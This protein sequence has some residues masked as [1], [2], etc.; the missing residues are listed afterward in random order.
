ME[1][2]TKQLERWWRLPLSVSHHGR[3]LQALAMLLC[4]MML[5]VPQRAGAVA[6]SDWG[7]KYSF[8]YRY[9]L[10]TDNLSKNDS[11]LK[12]DQ[13]NN[14]NSPY[15]QFTV[16]YGCEYMGYKEGFMEAGNG[17][18]IWA[19]K[20]G[21]S[22]WEKI[23]NIYTNE[24]FIFFVR[25]QASGCAKYENSYTTTE[26]TVGHY[27]HQKIRWTL[28]IQWRNCNIKLK[29]TG[30]WCKPNGSDSGS[31]PEKDANG[32]PKNENLTIFSIATPYTFNVRSISWNTGWSISPD[33]TITVPYKF[34]GTSRNT[35]GNTHI[36]TQI[37]GGY[38]STIGYKN[39]NKYANGSYTF[40]LKDIDM[41][42]RKKFTITPYH[43]FTHDN[44]KDNK[45]SRKDYKQFASTL[46]FSPFP[47][48][49]IENTEFIQLSNQVKLTW[50]ADNTNYSMGKWDTRWII[51]RNGVLIDSVFQ[52]ITEE[53][54][55]NHNYNSDTGTY[56]YIDEK[57]PNET[58]LEYEIYYV[59][60]DWPA[61]TKVASLKSI[62][63]AANSNKVNT[64]RTVPVK[65]AEAKSYPDSIVFTWTSDHY[66]SG[67]GHEF[68][69]YVDNETS[70]IYTIT[71]KDMQGEFKWI[72]RTTDQH[73][74][75]QAGIDEHGVPYVEEPLNACGPHTYRIQ[76]VVKDKELVDDKVVF[77]KRAIGNGTRFYSLD[78]TKGNHPGKVKLAWRVNLQGSTDAKTYVV[79]RRTAENEDEAW[80]QLTRM[81]S[82]DENLTYDDDTPLPGVYYD[83]RVTV[84]DKCSDGTETTNDKTDIGFAKTTGTV[85]GRIT[86]GSAGN[87]VV[88]ADVEAKKTG[89]SGESGNQYRSMH[90]TNNTG[91]VRWT[92]PNDTYAANNF[93]TGDFSIQLWMNPS[94]L[95]ETKTVRLNG[96]T[97]YVGMDANGKL[98]LVNG[99]NTLT[100]NDLKLTAGKYNHVALTRKAGTLTGYLI[101][102]DTAGMA[103]T[104]K[105]VLT[106]D[107]ALSLDG[108]TQFSMGYYQGYADEFRLWTKC[109][110]EA[111]VMENYDHLLVGN[112]AGLETYWTFDEGLKRK[113]FDYSRTLTVYHQHHGDVGNNTEADT[114]TPEEL[115]LKAKTDQ[116]GNFIIQGV[117]FSGEG[118][119]YA[120][121]PRLNSHEFSPTQQLRFVS[122][123]SL[124]HNGTDFTDISSFPVSGSI[125]YSGTTYPVE[126]VN[127][128]VDGI[129]CT[130]DGKM[131]TTNIDG[132]FEISVPIGEHY[133]QAV[134]NGHVFVNDGRYPADP[135]GIGEKANFDRKITGLEFRDTT[136]VNFTGRVVGGD[137]ENAY[138]V[139][140][141][142]SQNNIGI[143]RLTLNPVNTSPYINAVKQKISDTSFE[144]VYNTET[145]PV[146][147]ATDKINSKSW[148]G[149]GSVPEAR[150]IYIETDSLT[151]E[152]SALLP[153]LEYALG[154]MVVRNT[155]TIVGTGMTIDLTRATLE[156]SDTL[157]LDD[158]S[159]QI[160]TY[161]TKL[162][163]AYHSEPQLIVQQEGRT[164]GSFGIK[165]YEFK[166][167]TTTTT[168]SDI[169]EI[170]AD[171]K[172]KY[173]YGVPGH[174]AP[175]FREGLT[176][177]FKL[178]GYEEYKNYDGDP[179]HE[180]PVVKKVPLKDVEVIIGN[181]LSDGQAVWIVTGQV[182]ME[183]GQTYDAVAGQVVELQNNK[184]RLDENGIAKY[185]WRAGVPNVSSPYTRTISM[186][187]D[188]N[189]RQYQWNGSGLEGIILGDL[190][191]G[192]NFMT[193]GTDHLTMILRD[194][195]GTG[196]SA[197]WST[198]STTTVTTLKNDTWSDSAE[199][200]FTSHLGS[201]TEIM[202]GNVTGA[203]AGVQ[204]VTISSVK[205][206][207]KD[208]LTTHVTME[209]EGESGETIEE[210]TTIT[211]AV[212]TSGEPDF[213][214]ADG[215]I[216]IGNSTNIIFGNARRVGFMKDKSNFSIG[217]RNVI[218]TSMNLDGT[219]FMYTQGYIK[220]TLL[221][222]FK[223]L[224]Q[225]MLLT[226]TQA[227]ID[228]YNPVHDVGTHNLGKEAGNLYLTK[229]TPD[230][231]NFGEEGTYT[232]V[233]PDPY[234]EMPNSAKKSK[235]DMIAWLIKEKYATA[236][237]VE[238]INGQIATWERNLEL[239]EREKVRAYEL[240]NVKDS[241]QFEN[242]SF[243]GGSS[244]TY[245]IE[246]DS[247]HTSSWEWNV[248]A[249]IKVANRLGFE[250]NKTGVDWD[251]EITA[252]GGRHESRDSV[253]STTTSFS[254]TL[255][256]EGSDA[257]TVDVYQYGAFG[258]IF[259][260]RGGQTCNPY[261]DKDTTCYY[262]PGTVIMDKTMQ[263]EVPTISVDVPVISDVPTGSAANYSLHLGNG[264]EIGEDVAYRLYFLEETNPKGAQLSIDGK[265]LT[266]E[267]RL[268][269]VP[270]NQTLDKVLQ[271][272]QTDI[273]ELD[274]DSIAVVFASDSQPEDI[275]SVV[276]LSAHFTPSSSPVT[277]AMSTRTM[278]VLSGADLVLTIKDFDRNYKNLKAFRLQ[279][280]KEGSTDWTQLHEYVLN[281]EDLRPGNNELLPAG[282][283]VS[284][285]KPFAAFSDGNYIF[286][287]ESAATYGTEEVYRYS[288]EMALVKDMVKPRPLGTPEPADGVLDIG[289]DVT[290]TF[291]ETI[292]KGE[293]TK[294]NNF[295]VTGVLN[296]AEI[297]HET[298]LSV[299]SGSVAAT[300][301]TGINLA[302]KDFSIDTWVNI[303]T[304]GTLLTHG[305]G[306]NKLTVGTDAS[307]KLVVKIGDDT[308]TSTNSVPTGKWA[309]LTLNY[310]HSSLN[311]PLP[312]LNASVATADETVS[313]FANTDVAAYTGNGP[314]SV[315]ISNTDAVAAKA[316]MHE[317][318]LWDEAHDLTTALANRTKTKAP[319]TRHL[320][321]YWK[322]DEGEGK[323]IRDYSRSRNMTMANETW[324]LNNE[325]KAVTLDGSHYVT[326]DA[327]MLPI[328]EY[329]DYAVE[330]WMRG[331][332]QAGEAR[333]IQMGDIA[334][335]LN[336]DG[337]LQLK[338][339]DASSTT[340]QPN[341]EFVI[342]NSKLTD[343]AWHHI[344]LNVLRQGAAAVYVDGK[345]CLT[346]NAANV[347]G[348][349]TDRFVVGA[350]RIYG[351]GGLD[352]YTYDNAFKGEVDEVRV[353][354]ATMN[355][356]LLSK[357]RKLRFTGTEGGL[358]AYYPFETK[359]TDDYNQIV[360]VGT[361]KDLTGSGLQAQLVAL[362]GSPAEIG[363][364]NEA[365]ALRTKK[366]ETNVNFTY[367]A[368]DEKIVIEIDED[369][370]TIEGCTLNFNVRNVGDLNGNYSN[371]AIWSAFVNRNELVWAD[372]ALSL[373]QPVETSSSVTATI[374]NKGGKQQM[375]TLGG[376]PAWLT[377]SAEYGTTNPKSESQ[378]TFTVSPATPIGK[379]EETIYLKGNDGI[380][381]PL[382]INVK[383]TG[384]EPLW[385]VNTTDYRE[386]MNIIGNLFILDEMS[387]DEDD[388]V[389][390][391]I[392]DECRGVAHP[393]YDKRYDSYFVTMNVYDII[394]DD[395]AEAK[396]NNPSKIEFKAYDASTGI[397][398]PVVKPY[399][400]GKTV[401]ETML[402]NSN[403]LVG[404]YAKPMKFTATDEVEQNIELAKG[405]NWM[406]LGVKPDNFTVSDVFSKAHG[407]VEFVKGF[408]SSDEFDGDDWLI[409]TL[410]MNNREMYAVQT[411][412]AMTL[413]VTG[414]KVK[415]NDEPITVKNGW[416]WVAFNSLSVMSLQEGLAGMI[417]Q[418]EEIIK[419]QRGV[420][421]YDRYEWKGNLKQLTPGL[422]YKIQGKQARTFT[423]P[424]KTATGAA[425]R[426]AQPT[427]NSQLSTLN[428]QITTFT[429]VDYRNYPANMVLIAQVVADG[430][431]VSGV[432]LG[433]FAGEECREAAV[434]DERGMIYIT[435]PGDEPC[436]LTFSAAINGQWSMVNN[437]S[438]TYETDAVIG[439]PKA[440][441]IIDLANATGIKSICDLQIDNSRFDTDA[442]YDLQGRKIVN[443][444]SVNRKLRKGV[445][446]MNGQKK[447][448]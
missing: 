82:K 38:N 136:L 143:T 127:F 168:I 165:S 269:K 185:R 334:L 129:A 337:E 312:T 106:L 417:P 299:G 112:E 144:Y 133:I 311:S 77:A 401:P 301:E 83:Y 256:E 321:G 416:S 356:D 281:E 385:A 255:A 232:V 97:C 189:G 297:D 117:P 11:K 98:T 126:G 270:G 305:Q 206:E 132:E 233:V 207:A 194:P 275:C 138:P 361:P 8:L 162:T 239:N 266:S 179:K 351:A 202:T 404:R 49:V 236:D 376:M 61:K 268:F 44:D 85:S 26:Y 328:S 54:N 200:G 2:I 210:T 192:S 230:D 224:R 426:M 400:Y 147:S 84:I 372:D 412:E 444:E 241:V 104:K 431:P 254:Y 146:P 109:L 18:D 357:N 73:S 197:E 231:E 389:A 10:E 198:G 391:F 211:K 12:Y 218:S 57:F 3:P 260:T 227:E 396:A 148:R 395:D 286:R 191:S 219:T 223:K 237:S 142:L 415:S 310:S 243:D 88:G 373:T 315:G 287:C 350:R 362:N 100:F 289:D 28:P 169:Y 5:L 86:F 75:R 120:I 68:R 433:V 216:F 280:K 440:P 367:V 282:A 155:G 195:P 199:T 343:N 335:S 56:T 131:V 265:V 435:I 271:L 326:L 261:E 209:N 118:T 242:Y 108:A 414:H 371:D 50:K 43:E 380:E 80:T 383:V 113:F 214:G 296:G 437:Q 93:S 366:T 64:K 62:T 421:Y 121:I 418:D 30:T 411:N 65:E 180:S 159:Y 1:K 178:E 276:Y 42:F 429:P 9:L 27:Y 363:Y 278:N 16:G 171:G 167:A 25:N 134:L 319:S 196:S 336:A 115:K 119:T 304:A 445:Y 41:N 212:A 288:D 137:I 76:G 23:I 13:N 51:Y 110:T 292:V 325:N 425:S 436:E 47:I 228:Q 422:G 39:P 69:I 156:N 358:K 153:P 60:R 308:Y 407:K 398:Y 173:N 161:N 303:T 403:D 382:S 419:G 36:C 323:E 246:N 397:I 6:G 48:A 406:S 441:F 15:I 37:D 187:Y 35:D 34:E 114:F 392:D 128:Y 330:F 448:K 364:S 420:A 19:S 284:F 188:I 443:R 204:P 78:A 166:D 217:L 32:K 154:N 302:N 295:T 67:W 123:S 91:S 316:A 31:L 145:A 405:W 263:I 369:P 7:E 434:T 105:E 349:N 102:F 253:N 87:S 424:T 163:Q 359:T 40:N 309:F 352:P 139:G 89:A 409:G 390:A 345:R 103:V 160:Y 327:S 384:D 21:G 293:L 381:T 344:A 130:K 203:G 354:G 4:A 190:S 226:K 402:F 262:K 111:E 235:E 360:T 215:D 92:Y 331:G 427:L 24:N 285:T 177:L 438:I 348:I 413:S 170:D 14:G 279:Y 94:E 59:W 29:C 250:I 222:N 135:E 317:L 374:V 176:Y 221:P 423:Y 99:A 353:W 267:G 184:L 300:T 152:F 116:D 324:Y 252:T 208:D 370:A 342:S 238:W 151:G 329:D 220:N 181:A 442:V 125:R 432:E 53:G 172:V 20:D 90:F 149:G 240:H 355:G 225:R 251:L 71:P 294:M 447:V 74:D 174:E 368:S 446:I 386:N 394:D 140:F 46:T 79:E 314:L 22:S 245:T 164:D 290:I 33:S 347:G 264:S 375:W 248:K 70:P 81:S 58:D 158:G 320:I 101:A 318:L 307:N 332:Q 313:L 439:T 399:L 283:T 182:T 387:E 186:T 393:V 259:H 338:G 96:E 45:N 291:N 257:I 229:L 107:G 272:R 377:A 388:I 408:N 428:A 213:V 244:Y 410:A 346:T 322:M 201:V 17:L 379:Y 95:T 141:G 55:T 274:Y 63:R 52:R 150:T 124:V 249:G 72:H 306:S 378:V 333:L 258:P 122:N 183:N 277:L 298:A 430:Q 339:K 193:Q 365:P 157:T 234:V 66:P 340:A 247:T 341:S 175:L 205:V 273:S